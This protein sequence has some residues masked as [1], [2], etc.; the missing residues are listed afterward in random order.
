MELLA[1]P[2]ARIGTIDS[3]SSTWVDNASRVNIG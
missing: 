1:L 3:L 2:G